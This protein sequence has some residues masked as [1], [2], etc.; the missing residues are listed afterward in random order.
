MSLRPKNFDGIIGQDNVK[1]CLKIAIESARKRGDVLNHSLFLGPAGTG[2]TTLA[3]ATAHELGSNIL[4]ANGGNISKLKDVLPYLSRLSRGDVLFIDEVHRVNKRVQESL[5][6][7]MEDFRLDIAKGCQSIN[8]EPFTLIGATTE[9]G[10]LLR[11]FYDRF[12]HQFQLE[13]YSI[14]ELCKI[15][16]INLIKL[17]INASGKAIKNIA[18]RSRFTPRIANSLLQWCRDYAISIN[19]DISDEIV[20]KSMNLKK[21]DKNGL[22]NFDRQYIMVLRRAGKPLGV[23]TI[24]ASTGLSL[25]TIEHQIEPYLLK[26][27]MIEKSSKGRM[28]VCS[29]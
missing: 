3:L 20:N 8:F 28:L 24:A 22:D 6:T 23:R 26:L 2:K 4:L 27:G 17:N 21:I 5:F 9:A 14:E 18:Q 1:S 11:P 7:V 12:I 25:E 15:I 13:N 29:I 19:S 16:N 10:M